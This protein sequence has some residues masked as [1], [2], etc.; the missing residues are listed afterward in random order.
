MASICVLNPRL[1]NKRVFSELVASVANVG[2]KPITVRTRS[3]GSG[4][5]L[6]CGQ[7]RL[8]AFVELGQEEIPA[9]IIEATEEGT[10]Y[11]MSL[12]E[13]LARRQHSPL[14][15]IREIEALRAHVGTGYSRDGGEDRPQPRYI[16]IRNLHAFGEW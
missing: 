4:Y 12:V 3:D 8:E 16:C 7:G 1:R 14:E 2:L 13:N 5:D 15:L 6:V 11:L 9:I 10:C